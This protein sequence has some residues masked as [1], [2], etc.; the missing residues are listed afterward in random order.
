VPRNEAAEVGAKLMR[1]AREVPGGR[2]NVPPPLITENG[3]G[4]PLVSTFPSRVPVE[5]GKLVIVRVWVGARPGSRRE[6]ST[7]TVPKS[8]GTGLMARLVAG[9]PTPFKVT[10]QFV[11]LTT[12][13]FVT[14]VA[15]C[16][17][18]SV[19]VKDPG[20]VGEKLTT[21]G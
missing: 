19:C 8:T 11:A 5:V 21:T 2:L 3:L 10:V 17:R 13:Q 6:A 20:D 16:V 18:D 12:V 15:L 1:I 7:G 9:A 4:R 14:V